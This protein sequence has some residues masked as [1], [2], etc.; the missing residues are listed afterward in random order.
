MKIV[1]K[2]AC[3]LVFIGALNWGFVGFLGVDLVA[4]LFGVGS[5]LSM[6]VYDLVGLSAVWCAIAYISHKRSK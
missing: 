3:A 6:I 1:T 4:L 5:G 2:I